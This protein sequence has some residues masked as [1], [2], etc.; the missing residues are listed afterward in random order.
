MQQKVVAPGDVDD[1]LAVVHV[2]EATEEHVPLDGEGGDDHIESDARE[3]VALE[4]RHEE[5]EAD[6]D[7]DV[8]VL[9]H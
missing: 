2:E 1:D 4:E 3:A 7:H 8:H 5:P 6:E 9:K